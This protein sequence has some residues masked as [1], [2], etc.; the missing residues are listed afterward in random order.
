MKTVKKQR[1]AKQWIALIALLA[2]FAALLGVYFIV[3]AVNASSQ[4]E[5]PKTEPPEIF[6]G[7]SSYLN[8]PLAYPLLEQSE[9]QYIYISNENGTFD[10]TRPDEKGCFWLSYD[11]GNGIQNAVPYQPPILSAEGNYDYESLYAIENNDGYGRI[12]LLTYLCTAIG[13]PYFEERIPLPTGTDEQSVKER[14]LM[15]EEYGLDKKTQRVAFVYADVDDKGK[16]IEEGT[17]E[18]IIGDRSVMGGGFYFMVDGRDYVYFTSS[19]YFEYALR[20]FYSFIKGTLVAPG[21]PTDSTYEPYLTTDFKQWVNDTHKTEGEKIITELNGTGST[22][23][24]AGSSVIPLNKGANYVP[25]TEDGEGT[26]GYIRTKSD[27]L[28][29]DLEM[30][31]KHPDFK[32]LCSI[33]SGLT[34]DTDYSASPVL[35]T[36]IQDRLDSD[37]KIISF[38]PTKTVELTVN[39]TEINSVTLGGTKLSAE[40]TKVGSADLITVSGSYSDGKDISGVFTD[41]ELSFD[42]VTVPNEIKAKLRAEAVGTLEKAISFKANNTK[43]KYSYTVTAIESVIGEN[44]EVAAKG[45]A[46]SGYGLVKVTYTY[47][48]EGV[49]KSSLPRHAVID[50]NDPILPEGARAA[51]AS[52]FVGELSSPISFTVDYSENNSFAMRETLVIGDITAIYDSEGSPISVV[53]ADSYLTFRYYQTVNGVKGEMQSISIGMKEAKE[54]PKWYPITEALLGKK[55]NT[56]LSITVFS[57]LRYYEIMRDFISYEIEKVDFFI[58]KKMVTS[59]KFAN[60]SERDPF[61]GESYYEN[62]IDNEYKLYGLN[63]SACEGVVRFLGGIESDSS[64]SLGISGETVSLGLSYKDLK[65]FKYTIYFELP[66]GIYDKSELEEG[67]GDGSLEDMTDPDSTLGQLN[68]YGW[69]GTL[70]FTLYI[71]EEDPEDGTRLVASDMYDLVAKVDGEK[72]YFL[73]YEFVDFWARRSMML[74][75]LRELDRIEVD[76]NMKDVYGEFA[77]DLDKY[78]VYLVTGED[79]KKEMVNEKPSD[80]QIYT[81]VT[82][83][84]IFASTTR[85]SMDTELKAYLEEFKLFDKEDPKFTRVSLTNLYNYVLN[86][87]ESLPLVGVVDTVGVSNFKSA[88]ELLQTIRY[89]AVIP[90]ED[91]AA[92]EE[93][94]KGE[95]HMRI[96]AR[97]RG[98]DEF[99]TYDFYRY[100]DRKVMVSLYVTNEE[101]EAVSGLAVSDFYITTY[102]FKKLVGN[103]LGIA[104]SERITPGEGYPD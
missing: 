28:G 56:E 97:I 43:V 16:L 42:N 99:Y 81:T 35:I 57:D 94:L 72:F 46:V 96:R 61:Y 21:L 4:T 47:T 62:T 12:Y 84:R 33:L 2:V 39:I 85:D 23:V 93:A 9:I 49:N 24:A 11:N 45:T 8:R 58:T 83:D 37:S 88:Y 30:L 41:V 32:R 68:D 40:G 1:I 95:P 6:D 101:G 59:F 80:D 70:G 74:M 50:L 48:V 66:R 67:E 86:N 102:A 44:G 14:A 90:E 64:A 10:L 3:E 78:Q 103:F 89:Q 31:K 38:D 51:L 71:S 92:K 98:T 29:F 63:A 54:S 20:G 15:L 100:E 18:V 27:E 65:D 77:F 104:N 79:G 87:G 5:P 19:N 91:G 73:E 82:V 22:V 7:E 53:T 17:H 75:D 76:F 26:D 34:V 13:T 60:A 52:A 25:K 69:Y 55:A 36:L